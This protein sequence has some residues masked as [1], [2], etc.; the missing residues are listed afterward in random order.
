MSNPGSEYYTQ[1]ES[2]R[3]I[4]SDHRSITYGRQLQLAGIWRGHMPL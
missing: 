1:H 2:F 4:I 3:I